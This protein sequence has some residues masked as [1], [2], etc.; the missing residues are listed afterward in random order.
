MSDVGEEISF[1]AGVAGT[2]ADSRGVRIRRL[3]RSRRVPWHEIADIRVQLRRTKGPDVCRVQL[4]L[5]SGRTRMLPRPSSWGAG[6]P[7]FDEK[8]AALRA[9]H[10]RYGSPESDHLHV[11]S[12]RTAGR[13]PVLLLT[14]CALFLACAGL[15]AWSVP[16]TASHA[17]AWRSADFCTPATP[18]S[19]LDDC[20]YLVPAVIARTEAHQPKKKSWLYFAGGD[21][22]V[23]RLSVS[24]GAAV[25]FEPGDEVTLTLWRGE[26]M[27][28][29]NNHYVWHEHVTPAGDVAAVAAGLLVAA[30]FPGAQLLLRARGR[31]LPDD[32][33]LPS[34]LPFAVPLLVTGAWLVPLCYRYPAAPP[35]SPGALAWAGAG[36]VLTLSL[37]AWAWHAT[38]IRR[39][40]PI[41]A[42]VDEDKQ[43][44]LAARFLD[45]TDYNPYGNFGTHIAFG[46]GEPPAV[47][48]QG[49]TD[50]FAAKRIPVERLT[51]RTTR[52]ARGGDGEML[53]RSWHVAELDDAG[54]PVR[55]AA[56][57]ADLARI[58][59]A[60][61]VAKAAAPAHTET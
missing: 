30:G 1:G 57:P 41:G 51:V 33:V 11:V 21:P 23:K 59:H 22:I 15:A 50:R 18:A 12:H 25:A 27:R 16:A 7:D 47:L 14:M 44:C 48:P 38:R 58:L 3:L 10:R 31:R 34:G 53:R 20:R 17:Q 61:T 2:G 8:V 37:F 54:T 4:V 29:G 36:C 6:A 49:G 60:L 9:L 45:D 56:A 5:R 28:V 39:P 13:G 24:Q 35:S 32:E 43:V 42:T 46:G 19:E 52:R 40:E 55:L 26:V